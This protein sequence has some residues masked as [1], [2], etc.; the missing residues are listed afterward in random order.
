MWETGVGG[1]QDNR[2]T[3]T[4]RSAPRG[5]RRGGGGRE[6]RT[7]ILAYGFVSEHLWPKR[8][9]QS[10]ETGPIQ[11]GGRSGEGRVNKR[12][13]SRARQG[14]WANAADSRRGKERQDKK[15]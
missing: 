4:G 13:K 5:R 10:Q 14:L 3:G 8:R 15:A 12:G 6:S 9:V 7:D 2:G 1:V 11:R